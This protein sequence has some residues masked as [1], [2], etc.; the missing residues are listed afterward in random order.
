MREKYLVI[1]NILS[2][3]YPERIDVQITAKISCDVPPSKRSKFKNNKTE[4]KPTR[5]MSKDSDILDILIGERF[6]VSLMMT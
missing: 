1:F 5:R 3:I 4:A 6:D 2:T